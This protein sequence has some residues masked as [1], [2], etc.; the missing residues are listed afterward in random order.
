MLGRTSSLAIHILAGGPD[1]DLMRRYRETATLRGVQVCCFLLLSHLEPDI[2]PI[3][4]H[5]TTIYPA[6]LILLF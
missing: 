5:Q 6:L 2:F 4:F 3:H 1:G